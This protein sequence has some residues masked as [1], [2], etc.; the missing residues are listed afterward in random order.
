MLN[1]SKISQPSRRAP[2]GK[3]ILKRCVITSLTLLGLCL[4]VQAAEP[5]LKKGSQLSQTCLGCHGAPGLRNPGPVYQ[6]PM[7][8]GQH[9]DYIVSA[10]KS[11]KN[12]TRPHSTMRAQA[13]SLSEQDMIDIAAFFAA[14]DGNTRPGLASAEL[15]AKGEKKV[16]ACA[17]CHGKTGDGPS[18]AF[19]KLAGQYSSYLTQALKEY[20]S[21]ARVN[22]IMAG[23]SK[24]L[25]LDDIKAIS[26]YYASQDGGLSA[27]QSVI[28]K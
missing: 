27:P 22:A 15:I 18:S 3:Q 20:R 17:A 26:A 13:A 9:A 24:S 14:M 4:N 10:L 11:Y 8:G 5:D 23:Q 19:P 2:A 6:I 28:F 21:G 25:T 1:K 7:I 12:K 16:A